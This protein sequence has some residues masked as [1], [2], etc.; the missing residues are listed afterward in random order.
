M[1]F[2]LIIGVKIQWVRTQNSYFPLKMYL[3]LKLVKVT[4]LIE[5]VHAYD[6]NL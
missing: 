2:L 1:L 5:G 3:S 6:P 4:T